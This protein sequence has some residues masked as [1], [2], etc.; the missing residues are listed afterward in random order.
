MVLTTACLT[1]GVHSMAK[2]DRKWLD[3]AINASFGQ[4][5]NQSM[6]QPEMRPG[7]LR[8]RPRNFSPTYT[9]K[10]W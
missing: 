4:R 2:S 9:D 5:W 8:E 1:V 6:V 10:Q 7:N 3:T